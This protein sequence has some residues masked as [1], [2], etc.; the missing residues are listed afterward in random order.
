MQ[1]SLKKVLENPILS[2][3]E[4]SVLTFVGHKFLTDR[5]ARDF[6]KRFGKCAKEIT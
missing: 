4:I 5:N 2:G 6:N 1:R 3:S